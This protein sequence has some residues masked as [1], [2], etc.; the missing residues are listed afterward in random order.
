MTHATLTQLLEA[1]GYLPGGLPAPGLNLEAKPLSARPGSFAPDAMW[2]SASSITVYFKWEE[3]KPAAELIRRWRWEIWNE[4]KAPLLWVVTPE[5]IEL[6]NC[7]GKPLAKDDS[8]R[9]L[10]HSLPNSLE[11]LDGLNTLA[12]R[13]VMETGQA[14]E[15][16]PEVD[17][18]S[19]MEQRLLSSLVTLE[20]ALVKDGLARPS[21]Q[22]LIGQV[23]F[24]LY[25][26]DRGLLTPGAL[27]QV[28]G[29][30]TLA[31]A[32]RDGQAAEQVFSWL[33]ERFHGTLF[34]ASATAAKPSSRHWARVAGFLQ[35]VDPKTGRQGAFPYRFDLA[36]I[37]LIPAL[38][39]QFRF[40]ATRRPSQPLRAL[41]Q[42]ANHTPLPVVAWA[43]DQA[44]AGF[45]GQ[46]S[47]LD[48]SCGG[49]LFL[50]QAFRR[51]AQLRSQQ[52]PL[53]RELVRAVLYDQLCGVDV[54][55]AAIS[56]TAYSL[57]LTAL[58]LDPEPLASN[59]LAFK[60]LVGKNLL[61]G[62]AL[63][64]TDKQAGSAA[65]SQASGHEQF[66]LILGTLPHN[67]IQ[68][69]P[70]TKPPHR[71]TAALELLSRATD[72]A[73][74]KTRYSLVLSAK[75]MLRHSSLDTAVRH[76][77]LRN[78]V[79]LTL[80]NLSSLFTWP[81]ATYRLQAILLLAGHQPSQPHDGL[82]VAKLPPVPSGGRVLTFEAVPRQLVS[83]AY[84]EM[85]QHPWR[86]RAATQSSRNEQNLLL[87]LEETYPSLGSQLAQLG[88]GL[89]LGQATRRSQALVEAKETVPLKLVQ[90]NDLQHFQLPSWL[91]SY[92]LKHSQQPVDTSQL[93]PPLLIV[94][95]WGIGDRRL[96]AAMSNRQLICSSHYYTAAL[97]AG[98]ERLA[99][100]L[101]ALLNSA[102]AAWF[103]G[104]GGS[105]LG[106][107]NKTTVRQDLNRLP[108]PALAPALNTK[109]GRQLLRLEQRLRQWTPRDKD[110]LALDEAV[111]D[112]YG[113]SKPERLLIKDGLAHAKY[114][115]GGGRQLT[116]TSSESQGEVLDYAEVLLASF[117][118]QPRL[119]GKAYRRAEVI[120]LPIRAQLRMVRLIL[121]DQPRDTGVNLGLPQSQLRQTLDSL[122]EGLAAKLEAALVS[123]REVFV[124]SEGH[125]FIIK[126]AARLYWTAA[127]AL[128][129]A[130][131]LL[132][133]SARHAA[134]GHRERDAVV[135]YASALGADPVLKIA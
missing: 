97:P 53:T 8:V 85:E 87:R 3:T 61:V 126:P 64:L 52:A 9:H 23:I 70:S 123:A 37:E 31:E 96:I 102:L 25:L 91:P 107:H 100:L 90:K 62:N 82:G 110:W 54:D 104:L 79:P 42:N 38:H 88:T 66:D 78:L 112:L 13:L 14:W 48:P 129:D 133:L 77:A 12:G 101:A 75:T 51:L 39:K 114:Q 103:T 59:A 55:E 26:V 73:H 28:C 121:E 130:D 94:K 125:V 117:A 17:R 120:N 16:L 116:A 68:K 113:L 50:I 15:Q 4:G 32:V 57:Y 30:D 72:F 128:D 1:T 40:M 76:P 21:A 111:F 67:F 108:V 43:L 10:I 115:W 69:A 45:T 44:M 35:G 132:Q 33:A 118:D 19:G 109:A 34:A 131:S 65:L 124:H 119:F 86:L 93:Q 29:L 41:Y 49:G 106:H 58:E 71:H 2:R 92:R 47:A 7:Y 84:S 89:C 63:D 11:R 36:A 24:T 20:Q 18:K 95:E 74:E 99:A 6:Y 81:L 105:E 27:R 122:G 98:E 135:I 22:A 83:L 56:F 127:T 60:P 46:E 5:A 134:K 80:V